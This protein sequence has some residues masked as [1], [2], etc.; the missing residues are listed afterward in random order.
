MNINIDGNDEPIKCKNLVIEKNGIRYRLRFDNENHLVIIKGG[1]GS[2]RIQ[3][4][5]VVGNKIEII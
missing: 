3:I 4:T 2:D 1:E 5:P